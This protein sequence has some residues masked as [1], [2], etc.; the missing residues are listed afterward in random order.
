MFSSVQWQKTSAGELRGIPMFITDETMQEMDYEM[1]QFRA[2][3]GIDDIE[4]FVSERDMELAD[5][6]H[7]FGEYADHFPLF[8]GEFDPYSTFVCFD[9]GAEIEIHPSHERLY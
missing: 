4:R 7:E 1:A 3:S 8:G 5:C 2:M 6:V 9:C